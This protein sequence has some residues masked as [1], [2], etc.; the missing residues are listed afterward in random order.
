[1][2]NGFSRRIENHTAAV[3]LYSMYYNFARIH[4]TLKITPAMAAGVTDCVWD[5]SDIVDMLE[6]WERE[7]RKDK[8]I[9]E[10]DRWR[11]GGGYYVR[12][13]MPDGR[14]ERIE[15]FEIEADAAK[16][17]RNESVVWLHSIRR[18]ELA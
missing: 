17:I 9:I 13:T 12:V 14:V 11:I 4:Q 5:V 1:M 16:W 6:A 7:R 18:R 15:G 3:S 8:P 10:I 2:T